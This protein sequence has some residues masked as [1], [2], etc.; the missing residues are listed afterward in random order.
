LTIDKLADNQFNHYPIQSNKL[1][2]VMTK[3]DKGKSIDGKGTA[4]TA[5]EITGTS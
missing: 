4:T 2:E 5:I 1:K 3:S